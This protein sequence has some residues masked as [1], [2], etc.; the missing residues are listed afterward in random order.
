MDKGPY[1]ATFS[2]KDHAVVENKSNIFP[3]EGV[4]DERRMT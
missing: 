1:F 4:D 3:T 2:W